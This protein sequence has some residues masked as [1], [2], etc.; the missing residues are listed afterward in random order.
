[1]VI[2]SLS[3]K[4]VKVASELVGMYAQGLGGKLVIWVMYALLVSKVAPHTMLV[5][6]LTSK[7]PLTHYVIYQGARVGQTSSV[8]PRF[9]KIF[10][11]NN[12]QYEKL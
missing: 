11:L 3:T 8:S 5:S 10:N 6:V 4:V 2:P 7:M 9:F 1:M 12:H